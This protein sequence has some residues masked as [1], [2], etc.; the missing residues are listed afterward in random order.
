MALTQISTQGIKDGT[1][2]NADIGSSAAIARTKLANVD[3]V[4][5]TSPQLGGNLDTNGNL[6][7]FPDSNGTTNRLLFG[8]NK[9]QMYYNSG[10]S[11]MQIDN[12]TGD[13]SIRNQASGGDI[14]IIAGDDI[15]IRPQGGENGI[16][17]VGNGA[18]ELYHDNSKKFETTSAG[19]SVTGSVSSSGN[20]SLLD[21][22]AL[23]LGTSN[24][25]T[26]THNGTNSVIDNNT[27]DLIIRGDGDDVKILAE[28]D[29]FLR[30]NDDTTNFI[31]CINGGAVEL[32]H[33]GSKKFETLTNGVHIT[34]TTFLD[35]SSRD[36]GFKAKFGTGDDLQIYHDGSNSYIE[37]AGTGAL[38][39]KSNTLY[40]TGTNAANDLASFVEGGAVSLFH[41]D[42]KKFETT[43]AGVTIQGNTSTTGAFVSTQ[44][45]GGVLSDNLSL[46]DNKKVKLGAGDDLQLYHNGTDS[47]VSNS[48]NNLRIGNTHS[49][50]I[51]F[52]TN[53]SVRWNISGDGTFLPDSNNAYDI[54]TSSYRVRNIYTN[55][56]NLSNEGGANDVDGTWGSYT[57][58]EGAE[59]LFLIN[60]RS[61]KKYKFNLTEVS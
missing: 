6:V 47:Y 53:N 55:D 57:I 26:L 4:D 29:I 40:L 11:R 12:I 2:T 43:S 20:I 34:G 56:L 28:D 7:I 3:L 22:S 39:I 5:D 33:N 52:F 45:G 30:D 37:D 35:D 10:N 49:N 50:N 36:D 15:R 61:G 13:F 27:G 1:I 31:H 17:L 38:L 54:G 14:D 46:T 9:F 58:Q 24:D 23:Q 41:N 42:S 51:K 59:D 32:Y 18:V 21:T 60:K 19:V 44:T 8:T 48:T 16:N 25:F